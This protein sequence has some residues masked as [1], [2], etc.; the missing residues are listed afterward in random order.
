MAATQTPV[1]EKEPRVLTEDVQRVLRRAV[2]PED[3]DVGDSVV[4]LAQRAH[5]SA[6]TI[7]RILSRTTYALNLDLADRCCLAANGHLMECRL[8]W[9][10]GTVSDYLG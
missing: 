1:T 2:R 8:L 9:P 3:D 10:D 7:Y 6:R 4:M 5:T